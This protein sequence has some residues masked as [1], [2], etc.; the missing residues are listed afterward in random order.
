M[1]KFRKNQFHKN[2]QTLP[3]VQTPFQKEKNVG[4]IDQKLR[5]NR[6]YWSLLFLFDFAWFFNS[7]SYIL[8]A[9]ARL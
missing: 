1:K 2:S 8:S 9:I 4:D 6:Y 5:K 7:V 3:N